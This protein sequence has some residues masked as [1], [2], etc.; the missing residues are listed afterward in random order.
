MTRFKTFVS[1][2]LLSFG[3]CLTGLFKLDRLYDQVLF[4]TRGPGP[5]AKNFFYGGGAYMST[6]DAS[7]SKVTRGC[8]WR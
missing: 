1:L 5:V 7:I 2:W 8:Q 3:T 6:E 4:Q